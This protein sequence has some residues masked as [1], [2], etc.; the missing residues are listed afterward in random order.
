M[1]LQN[2]NYYALCGILSVQTYLLMITI[3]FKYDWLNAKWVELLK[4]VKVKSFS[5]MLERWR[6]VHS[7]TA[8]CTDLLTQHYNISGSSRF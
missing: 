1:E 7:G 2:N 8:C 6:L 4:T 5:A 3:K